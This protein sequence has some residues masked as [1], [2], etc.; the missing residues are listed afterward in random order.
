LQYQTTIYYITPDPVFKF[1]SEASDWGAIGM[2]P[3]NYKTSGSQMRLEPGDAIGG[4]RGCLIFVHKSEWIEIPEDIKIWYGD[5]W[6]STSFK[7]Q[8]KHV[9]K[10]HTSEMIKTKMST[11]C[12]IPSL[13][14]VIQNDRIAWS[15]LIK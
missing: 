14:P 9:F 13:N 7:K 6:I 3:S 4:V 11:S 1:V 5:N 15:K 8:N 2:S 10:L 12:G